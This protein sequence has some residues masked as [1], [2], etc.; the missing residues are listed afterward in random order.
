MRKSKLIFYVH[1]L[2][3][4]LGYIFAVLVPISLV[5]LLCNSY[6]DFWT[7]VLFLGLLYSSLIYI[8][9][10]LSSG[11]YGFCVLT[12]IENNFR[13]KEGLPKVSNR[14]ILRFNKMII[15]IFKRNKKCK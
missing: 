6:L 10:H 9:N 12:F 13:E 3:A 11:D 7:K 2:V 5:K 4:L 1:C 14:F 15:N 8:V